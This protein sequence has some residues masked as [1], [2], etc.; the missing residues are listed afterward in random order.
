MAVIQRATLRPCAR[1]QAVSTTSR[2][3]SQPGRR[4]DRLRYRAR[5]VTIGGR[6]R[7]ARPPPTPPNRAMAAR[8]RSTA[9][10]MAAGGTALRDDGTRSRGER[11]HL[12]DAG[13]GLAVPA[14]SGGLPRLS[15]V[16]SVG[17]PAPHHC[18]PAVG[19]HRDAVGRRVRRG[20]PPVVHAGRQRVGGQRSHRGPG[21]RCRRPHPGQ[22]GR[23]AATD[24]SGG[25]ALREPQNSA[26]HDSGCCPRWTRPAQRASRCSTTSRS[27]IW[28]TEPPRRQQP[29]GAC[30]PNLWH[31]ISGVALRTSRRSIAMWRSALR[32][33]PARFTAFR[34]GQVSAAPRTLPPA[35]CWVCAMPKPFTMSSIHSRQASNRMCGSFRQRPRSGLYTIT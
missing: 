3:H 31:R 28:T 10:A 13:R 32:H 5:S 12:P 29:P 18:R 20:R 2:P 11:R 30:R 4:A 6:Q 27:R 35:T 26:L 17:H 23:R 22:P 14:V 15:E 33:R 7:S 16:Q 8:L 24:S 19:G 9:S 21:A 34:S 1:R 25:R